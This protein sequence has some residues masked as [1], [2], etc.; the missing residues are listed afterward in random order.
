MEGNLINKNEDPLPVTLTH[1]GTACADK[2]G[3]Q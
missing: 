1:V 3:S 2:G